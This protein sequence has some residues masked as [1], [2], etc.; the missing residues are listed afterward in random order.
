[1]QIHPKTRKLQSLAGFLL[2]NETTSS[3][4]IPSTNSRHFE[5]RVFSSEERY[6]HE[7]EIDWQ[8]SQLYP[9]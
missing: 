3:A 9:A 2:S 7:H 1:M 8:Q 4:L 6:L 5:K